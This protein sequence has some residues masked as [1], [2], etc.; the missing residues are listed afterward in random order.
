MVRRYV[1]CAG[2]RSRIEEYPRVSTRAGAETSGQVLVLHDLVGLYE[3]SPR[4]AKRYTD[5]GRAI[6]D[7]L[8]AFRADVA[9][10]RFPARRGRAF[11]TGYWGFCHRRRARS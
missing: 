1:P 3:R 9:A 6:G 4:F 2:T 10:R 7:A 5:A 8:A 11:Q